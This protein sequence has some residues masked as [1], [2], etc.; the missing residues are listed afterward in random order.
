[1]SM[2]QTSPEKK[3]KRLY[4]SERDRILGGVAGGISEYFNIDSNIIRIIFILLAVFGGSGILIYLVLWILLPAKSRV[5]RTN[6]DHIKTNVSEIKAKAES[7]AGDM[8]D[9]SY[10]DSSQFW[11]GVLIVT[12]GVVF[13]LNNFGLFGFINFARLWPLI[14]ILLGLAI[15]IKR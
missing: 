11:L 4:R 8:R 13:L 7:F 6:D 14:L 15:L 1:M 12:I 3:P 5:D 2:E 10:Q 9:I